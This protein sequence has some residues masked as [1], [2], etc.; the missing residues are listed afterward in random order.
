MCLPL[1]ARQQ[2][3]TQLLLHSTY[4]LGILERRA[5]WLIKWAEE[6]ASSDTINMTNFEEGLGRSMYFAWTLEQERP[7]LSPLYF[8]LVEL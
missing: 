1:G 3:E 6:V 8:T 5:A 4:H 7:F 2:A